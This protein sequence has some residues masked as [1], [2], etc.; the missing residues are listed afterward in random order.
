MAVGRCVVLWRWFARAGAC[1][2]P[3][4]ALGEPI[5]LCPVMSLLGVRGGRRVVSACLTGSRR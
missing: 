3:A 4:A 2:S 1:G 5:R